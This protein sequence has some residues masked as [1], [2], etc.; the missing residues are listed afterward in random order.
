MWRAIVVPLFLVSVAGMPSPQGAAATGPPTTAPVDYVLSRAATHKV[1]LVG[2]AHWIRHDAE[3]LQALAARAADAGVHV[4]GIEWLPAS[5]QG[6]ITSVTTA[7]QWNRAEAIAVLRTAGWPYE[8]Y[9]EALHQAWHANARVEAT[10]Q[11]R[12]VGLSPPQ[13]WRE[14]LLPKGATYDSFMAERVLESVKGPGQRAIVWVGVSHMFARYALP[15]LPER[16]TGRV[17]RV[18][19]RTGNQLWRQLGDGLFSV[20]LH[21]PWT[22]A[23]GNRWGRCLP[24]DAALDCALAPGGLPAGFDLVASPFGELTVTDRYWFG[25]GHPRRRLLDLADGYIWSRPI[26]SYASV[27][28]IPLDE[29]A[30]DDRALREVLANNPVTDTARTRTELAIAWQNRTA[31]M[32]RVH[33]DRG[34]TSLLGW[35]AGCGKR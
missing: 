35:Q 15:D 32:A 7:P 19:D 34:W 18:S 27:S 11:L 4:L 9:L 21:Y 12:V 2:E 20:M 28:L 31:A 24:L 14:I 5:E 26:E 33:E 10:R 3:L 1:V 13:N 6:R 25:L 29:F 8:E 23:D 30:P 16:P 17:T 22:C